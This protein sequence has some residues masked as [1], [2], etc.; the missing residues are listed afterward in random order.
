MHLRDTGLIDAARAKTLTTQLHSRINPATGHTW[1]M[2]EPGWQDRHPERPR[3]LRKW[4]ERCYGAASVPMLAARE[5]MIYPPDLLDWFLATQRPAPA[6]DRH[7]VAAAI[8]AARPVAP[9]A[10]RAT[11]VIRLDDFRRG[12]TP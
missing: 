10:E 9:V 8:C 11:P 5:S 6:A 7:P 3:L 2:T 1:G 4:V 12:K